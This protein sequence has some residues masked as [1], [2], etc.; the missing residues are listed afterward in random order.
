MGAGGLLNAGARH[1]YRLRSQAADGGRKHVGAVVLAAGLSRRLGNANKLL[2]DYDGAP[3]ISR[4]VDAVLGSKA[5]PIVVVTGYE[6]ARVREALTGREVAFVHNS[7][8]EEG[9]ARSVGTG[10]RALAGAVDAAVICLGDMPLV[11]SEHID[12]LI[13]AFDPLNHRS[14]CVPV[15]G[16]T[17]GNPVLWPARHFAE[18]ER[19]SG[20]VGARTLLGLH[21]DDVLH[22]EVGDEGVTIDVDTPEMLAA[23]QDT[24]S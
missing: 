1:K 15:H 18:L 19:L 4:A 20:D 14:I 6:A 13:D 5:R 3:L 8:Y 12:A 7:G 9:L 22:V 17:R 16:T 23:L 2:A 11:K 24:R 10:I 21:A